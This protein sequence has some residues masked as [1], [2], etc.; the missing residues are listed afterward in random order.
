M[1][2]RLSALVLSLAMACSLTL[3][4]SAANNVIRTSDVNISVD[5]VTVEVPDGSIWI[6]EDGYTMVGARALAEGLGASIQWNSATRTAEITGLTKEVGVYSP[7]AAYENMVGA[8]AWQ[9]S[10]ECH[11]L[12][13]QAFNIAKENVDEMVAAAKAGEDGFS[14]KD[15]KLFK[16]GKRVA[17]FSDVDDTLVD[18]V[19][20]T[21]N[22]VGSNGDWN[23]AAFARFVMSDGCT[24]LPGA[25][26]F[27]NYCV[28]NGIEFFYV[29]NRYD[30]G[31]KVGQS[32]SKGGYNGESGYVK[33]D[34][35]VIGSSVYQVVGKTF[36]DISAASMTKLG[37]PI[38]ADAHLITND[39]KLNGSNKQ[40]MRDIVASGGTWATGERTNES[41][42]YPASM[43][44][45][46]HFIAMFVGDDLNDIN[47]CFSASGVDAVSRVQTAIDNMDKWGNE[48]IVLPNA[49]YGSSINYASAYGY[50]NLFHYFDYTNA[51]TDAWKLYQ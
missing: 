35:T 2:K 21:A 45:D 17:V 33:A 6:S 12:M 10:A 44:I 47:I 13:M 7:V 9:M 1:K 46:E 34:G 36:Y 28:D 48:W 3:D 31:Y 27:V 4:A 42:A 11:A 41:T 29:T 51:S 38:N 25:V 15:G 19:H 37:F 18:G 14:L 39:N 20:Y 43:A 23:N 26:E 8:A 50:S 40:P 49:V 24:A 16:D 5:G 30:Q 22:V 32:D